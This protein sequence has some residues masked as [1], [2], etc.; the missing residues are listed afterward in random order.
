MSMNG[1]EF[2]DDGMKMNVYASQLKCITFQE[3]NS[4]GV[5]NIWK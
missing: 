5:G 3:N 1:S 4:G 2:S